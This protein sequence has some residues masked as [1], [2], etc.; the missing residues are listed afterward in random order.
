MAGDV[1]RYLAQLPG[2]PAK[3]QATLAALRG[4]F[5]LLVMRHICLIN[6]AAEAQTDR[7][8]IVEGKTPEITGKQFRA[9]LKVI[10]SSTLTG[11]RDEVILKTLAYTGARVGAVAALERKDFK[12]EHGHWHLHFHE[13]RAKSRKIPVAHNLQLLLHDYLART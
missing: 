9:L 7:Y 12:E 1:G 10:N 5:R 13:K 8:E 4:H 6:P 11:L 3:K 2:G